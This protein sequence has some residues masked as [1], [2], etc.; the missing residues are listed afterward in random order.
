MN[1]QPPPE[2]SSPADIRRNQET[3]FLDIDTKRN[4]DTGTA[5]CGAEI[6]QR[7]PARSPSVRQP[8][9]A[10]I[11]L[12]FFLISLG[13]ECE[14]CEAT[15]TV[16]AR[17]RPRPL[18]ATGSSAGT[19]TVVP[20][21]CQQHE[22]RKLTPRKCHGLSAGSDTWTRHEIKTVTKTRNS[23]PRDTSAGRNENSRLEG[24]MN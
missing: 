24:V 15:G 12:Q 23:G 2:Q 10:E 3:P 11:R 7:S 22:W 19:G 16:K 20:A 13:I 1:R 8:A 9:P 17:P 5:T 6:F 18:P 14:G 21:A 4:E